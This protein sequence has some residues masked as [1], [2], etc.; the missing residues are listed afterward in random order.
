MTASMKPTIAKETKPVTQSGRLKVSQGKASRDRLRKS[1]WIVLPLGLMIAVCLCLVVLKAYALTYILT[2]S[3]H[4]LFWFPPFPSFFVALFGGM[5]IYKT[6]RRRFIGRVA[7]I[8]AYILLSV[9]V[10]FIFQIAMIVGGRGQI[11]SGIYGVLID[12]SESH[13]STLSALFANPY[14]LIVVS[15]IAII[16]GIA[17][18]VK[19]RSLLP[20]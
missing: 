13:A 3:F 7:K 17:L 2:P 8:V 15:G 5:Y 14:S 11:C 1:D 10:V 12:C 6:L 18:L 4:D 9:F 16:G 20:K 19:P